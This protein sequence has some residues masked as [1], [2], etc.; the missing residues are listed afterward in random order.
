MLSRAKPVGPNL[1]MYAPP[2]LLC[3]IDNY[4]LQKV[5][6]LKPDLRADPSSGVRGGGP[7]SRTGVRCESDRQ[8]CQW[9]AG[10]TA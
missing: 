10:A 7:P 8:G 3:S 6:D 9:L 2:R 1:A 5:P 4:R